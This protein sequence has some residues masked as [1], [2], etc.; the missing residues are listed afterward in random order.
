M[1]EVTTSSGVTIIK[2]TADTPTT[3]YYY[4]DVH[5]GM[6]ADITVEGF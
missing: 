6:G 3:L 1:N 4:C 2:I 5:S